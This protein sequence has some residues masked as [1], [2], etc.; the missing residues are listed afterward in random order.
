MCSAVRKW[1]SK[2]SDGP[3]AV[4][5][6]SVL[7]AAMHSV[8]GPVAQTNHVSGVQDADGAD[9]DVPAHPLGALVRR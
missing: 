2:C 3:L 6:C 4:E 5:S 9:A 8:S 1:R 7:L